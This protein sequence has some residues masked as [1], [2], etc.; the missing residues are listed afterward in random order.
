VLGAGLLL[1]LGAPLR[2][3]EAP[4]PAR[5]P[6][7]RDGLAR[8]SAALSATAVSAPAA[9]PAPPPSAPP[10]PERG[11]PAI[12]AASRVRDAVARIA[13]RAGDLDGRPALRTGAPAPRR[14]VEAA[15]HAG[16]LRLAD[17]EAFSVAG[18]EHVPVQAWKDGLP[19]LNRRGRVHRRG[20]A[21]AGA[22]GRL[23]VPLPEPGAA[24]RIDAATAVAL[25]RSAAGA[26][27]ERASPTAQRGWLARAGGSVPAWRVRIAS[28]VPLASWQVTLHAGTGAVLDAVDLLVSYRNGVGSV[29]DPNL[30]AT[31]EPVDRP[32]WG[33][34][35]S[36]RLSGAVVRVI[37]L[38]DLEAFRPDGAFRF[39]LGDPR[40]VQTNAYR[41]ITD[42]IVHMRSLG[43]PLRNDALLALVNIGGQPGEYNNAFYDPVLRVLGFGNGDGATTANLGTD[44]DV[45]AHEAGHYVFQFLVDPELTSGDPMLLS[46]NEATADSIAA[47]LHGD[48]LIGETTIPGQPALRDLGPL[49]DFTNVTSDDPHEIGLVYGSANWDLVERIGG[50][51][52]G[53]ILLAGLPFLQPEPELPTEYRNALRSGDAAVYAG[54]FRAAI[55][56]VF[57]E[58]GFDA[59]D[60]FADIGTLDE[61]VPQS[62]VVG[63]GAVAAWFFHEFPGSERV[64]LRLAGSG[65]ADLFAGPAGILDFDDPSTFRASVTPGTTSEALLFSA[66]SI[67][68][69]D[70]DDT[71]VVFVSDAQGDGLASSY[72]LTATQVL[73]QPA[74][75]AG[76]APL[77]GRID[78][79]GEVDYLTFAGAEGDVVRLEAASLDATMDPAVAVFDPRAAESGAIA[80]DDDDGPGVDALIQGARLPRSGIFGIAVLS[81]A[82]DVDPTVGTGGYRLHLT[83]CTASGADSDGDGLADPCDDD[84]DGD[85]FDDPIDASPLDALRCADYDE[86]LCDDCANGAWNLFAD[87]PDV[88][89]DGY[90]DAGDADDDNDGCPDDRDRSPLSAS[91]DDDFDFL[92]DHCDNCPAVAN[93]LQEDC[94]GN[95]IGDACD[96]TPCPEP[97]AAAAAA[98]ASLAAARLRRRGPRGAPSR[99]PPAPGSPR[100]R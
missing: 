83:L 65:D 59:I 96:A 27:A 93:P 92:G 63:E 12:S 55:D 25:A 72:T 36:G 46:M 82:A 77:D 91:A 16:A 23:S 60:S 99:T 1:G 51:A 21:Y 4:A 17:G 42:T 40:F 13:A 22:T 100:S 32:L 69:V 11:R 98:L 9:V 28:A 53:R 81:P 5:D 54:A 18:V 34:D 84:D 2:I 64:E 66:G 88:E 47:L 3:A 31:P 78:A 8:S 38:R 73:P 35:E 50:E 33:L 76:G 90:C 68:S 41:S 67:P 80:F 26:R 14:W 52:F 30:L 49:R 57:A 7:E 95:G 39:P 15:A 20:G 58:R 89:S 70:A 97:C 45:A 10:P 79:A 43:F 29:Y 6:G 94:N 62:G 85:A 37:D 71:W 56:A 24:W 74:V 19:V 87:G 75:V 61:G 86:D 48:P 44:G